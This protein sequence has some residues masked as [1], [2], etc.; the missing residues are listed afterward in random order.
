MAWQAQGHH[1]IEALHTYSWAQP[2]V[3]GTTE[4]LY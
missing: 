3:H 4:L 1:T 2:I